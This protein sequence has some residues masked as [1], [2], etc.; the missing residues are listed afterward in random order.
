MHASPFDFEPEARGRTR[1]SRTGLQYIEAYSFWFNHPNWLINLL[2]VTVCQIIPIV[3]P[4]VVLGYE[5]EVIL[6]KLRRT[7][8]TYPELDFGRFTDYLSRGVWPFLV[9]LIQGL[10]IGPVMA[11]V[12]F[13]VFMLAGL[14]AAAQGPKGEPAIFLLVIPVMLVLFTFFV[15]LS[16][17]VMTPL[18]LR[19]GLTQDLGKAF[20]W[21]FVKDFMHRVGWETVYAHGFLMLS[22]WVALLIGSLLCCVGAYPATS[23]IL[24]AHTHLNWQLY[25]LYLARGGMPI[26]LPEDEIIDADRA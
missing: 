20:D 13:L 1:P 5:Y 9:Q 11:V 2:L 10:V 6:A 15:T 19:A 8:R 23:L 12:F 4:I 17:L 26:P 16:A 25:E 7:T 3:G 22:A 14:G 18:V 24:L 21:A